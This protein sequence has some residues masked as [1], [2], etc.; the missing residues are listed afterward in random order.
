MV[1]GFYKLHL[2]ARLGT[3]QLENKFTDIFLK[4]KEISQINQTFVGTFFTF[5]NGTKLAPC[6]P[7]YHR[8]TIGLFQKI[9]TPPMDELGT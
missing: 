8:V 6:L 9:S 2:E 3:I 5:N 7:P 1:N 4:W